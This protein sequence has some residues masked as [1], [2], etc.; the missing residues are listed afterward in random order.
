MMTLKQAA[1][2]GGW[3]LERLTAVVHDGLI[4]HISFG[5]VVLLFRDHFL[6][7]LVRL[8]TGRSPKGDSTLE[9]WLP[10][11]TWQ[12]PPDAGN[13]WISNVRFVA[14]LRF[15]PEFLGGSD[16]DETLPT[17]LGCQPEVQENRTTPSVVEDIEKRWRDFQVFRQ[18][19]QLIADEF[20]GSL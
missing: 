15:G 13:L 11:A 9:I 3:D 18:T 19:V 8:K 20:V 12:H 4:P 6:L 14:D 16:W 10:P 2:S 5:G 1:K 7:R 17:W